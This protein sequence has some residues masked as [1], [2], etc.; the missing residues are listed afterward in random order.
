MGDTRESLSCGP[1]K[2]VFE[3][4]QTQRVQSNRGRRPVTNP[5]ASS[6]QELSQGIK[7]AKWETLNGKSKEGYLVLK[8]ERKSG[9]EGKRTS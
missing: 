7:E 4:G 6:R 2:G 5:E 1:T 3:R 9:G 8:G